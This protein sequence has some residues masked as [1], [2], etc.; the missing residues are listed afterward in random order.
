MVSIMPVYSRPPS[1]P[2]PGSSL[3]VGSSSRFG[4]SAPTA[5]LFFAPHSRVDYLL[6]PPLPTIQSPRP[7]CWAGSLSS[8]GPVFWRFQGHRKLLGLYS[9]WALVWWPCTRTRRLFIPP[10]SAALSWREGWD[11]ICIYFFRTFHMNKWR[12]FAVDGGTYW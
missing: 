3:C 12:A 7:C 6:T 2:R 4:F 1:P 11:Y 10:P 9:L 8:R 5:R